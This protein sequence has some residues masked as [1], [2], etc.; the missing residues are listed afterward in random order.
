MVLEG[1]ILAALVI[2]LTLLSMPP[3]RKNNLFDDKPRR[4]TR[5]FW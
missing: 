3:R 2:G 1:V 4:T 5:R